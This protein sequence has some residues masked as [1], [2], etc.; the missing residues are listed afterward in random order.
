[1]VPDA[2]IRHSERR[3]CLGALA[4]TG[5]FSGEEMCLRPA[6]VRGT[7]ARWRWAVGWSSDPGNCVI[8]EGH[9][10]ASAREASVLDGSC[11]GPHGD[12]WRGSLPVQAQVVGAVAGAS[13]TLHKPLAP[14]AGMGERGGRAVQR[15]QGAVPRGG[16][17]AAG[18][19]GRDVGGRADRG[20][21][22]PVRASGGAGFAGA[23][24]G[25]VAM[26]RALYSFRSTEPNSLPFAAGE[27]FLLLERSNQHWWLVTRAGS[28][29]TGYAPASYLQRLQVGRAGLGR[30]GAALPGVPG[31]ASRSQRGFPGCPRLGLCRRGGRA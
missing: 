4:G 12:R 15:R 22:S 31:L 24:A 1:M 5:G 8:E 20:G 29:E 30:A 9:K 6:G 7:G 13:A 28:G 17:G 16:R 3:G 11:Q 10:W 25:A 26:Y 21:A 14:P 19:W 18:T 2:P 27:T 23:G